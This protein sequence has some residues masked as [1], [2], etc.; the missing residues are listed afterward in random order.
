VNSLASGGGTLFQ[1]T[2]SFVRPANTTR[3]A[4]G[5]LVANDTVGASC[6][7][8]SYGF[9]PAYGGGG[10]ISSVRVSKTGTAL[11][12]LRAHFFGRGTAPVATNGD[13]AAF[14]V[15]DALTWLG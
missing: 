7:P 13:G 1:N 4:I 8:L 9:L 11:R 2:Q 14:D 15:S 6:V 12:T 5:N 10:V 3:Y